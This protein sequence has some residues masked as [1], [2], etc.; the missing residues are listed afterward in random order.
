MQVGSTGNFLFFKEV[1]CQFWFLLDLAGVSRYFNGVLRALF[2]IMDWSTAKHKPSGSISD[3]F[4]S[5]RCYLNVIFVCCL[6][7]IIC[8]VFVRGRL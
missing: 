7:V 5:N 8:S 3:R 4:W 1:W 2:V 6:S